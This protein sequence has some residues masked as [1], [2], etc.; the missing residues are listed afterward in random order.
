MINS[1]AT[2]LPPRLSWTGVVG[3]NNKF[4]YFLEYLALDVTAN[5]ICEIHCF[6]LDGF[7]LNTVHQLSRKEKKSRLSRD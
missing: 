4:R 7:D 3:P 6:A 5:C 1:F 2:L